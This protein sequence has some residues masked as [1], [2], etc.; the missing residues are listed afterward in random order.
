MYKNAKAWKK[1]NNEETVKKTT[2]CRKVVTI[3]GVLK[4]RKGLRRLKKE[5]VA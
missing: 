4:V 1:N 5:A 3:P 2:D